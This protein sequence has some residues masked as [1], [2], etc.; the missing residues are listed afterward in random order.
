M[1]TKKER[2]AAAMREKLT[3]RILPLLNWWTE[4]LGITQTYQI[5]LGVLDDIPGHAP[6][7]G[8]RAMMINPEHPYKA[9]NLLVSSDVVTPLN[10][11]ELEKCI[12]HEL[13]H[14]LL[15]PMTE[16]VMLAL[17]GPLLEGVDHQEEMVCD[18]LAQYFMRLKYGKEYSPITI[19]R[20]DS[21][22]DCNAVIMGE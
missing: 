18:S 11:Q 1:T 6:G 14:I 7:G 5:N 3:G 22:E 21:C 17:A 2:T 19:H 13:M 10:D 12:V 20:A 8:V 15:L 4:F 9:I 16:L